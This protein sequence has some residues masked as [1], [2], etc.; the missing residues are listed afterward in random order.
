MPVDGLWL[1]FSV[2]GPL[3]YLTQMSW[4]HDRSYFFRD[5]LPKKIFVPAAAVAAG[6]YIYAAIE[7]SGLFE[8][9]CAILAVFLLPAFMRTPKTLRLGV[10]AAAFLAVLL[11]VSPLAALFAGVFL[12]TVVHVGLFTLLFLL[13]GALR[14]NSIA[15]YI[16]ALAW[17]VA[18]VSLFLLPPSGHLLAGDWA[19][20]PRIFWTGLAEGFG[21]VFSIKPSTVFPFLTFAYTYHFLNWFTKT[22]LLKWH[23]VPPRRQ[24]AIGV[25]LAVTLAACLYDYQFGYMTLLLPLSIMHVLLEFP[26]DMQVI[27]GLPALVTAKIAKAHGPAR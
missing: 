2:L 22:E 17:I 4:L 27:L 23:L 3:H 16:S 18:A 20:P 15:S 8:S 26:L 12:P 10:A 13:T 14:G 21:W 11:C 9:A 1:S 24:A 6:F 5:P 7:P 25:I 19:K